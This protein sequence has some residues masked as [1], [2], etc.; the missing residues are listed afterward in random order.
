[1]M[2]A[3]IPRFFVPDDVDPSFRINVFR[4]LLGINMAIFEPR[5]PELWAAQPGPND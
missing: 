5:I 4:Q 1:M 3:N 2:L